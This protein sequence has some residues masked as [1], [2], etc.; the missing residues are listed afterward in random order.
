MLI[1][2]SGC[3]SLIPPRP[4]I[5][6]P[7]DTPAVAAQSS[8]EKVVVVEAPGER[9]QGNWEDWY[10]FQIGGQIVGRSHTRASTVIDSELIRT[11]DPEVRFEREES[12]IY[13]TGALQFTQRRET[14]SVESYDGSLKSFEIETQT[15]P[16]SILHQAT[17]TKETLRLGIVRGRERDSRQLTWDSTTRGLFAVEQSLRRRPMQSGETRRLRTAVPSLDAIGLTVLRCIGDASVPMIAGDFRVLTEIELELLD[18]ENR[19]V[20]E[21]L[22]WTDKDGVI[23]KSLRP[24]LRL[25]S[26]RVTS[27]KAKELFSNED[28]EVRVWLSGN[29]DLARRPTMVAML[30]RV[31]A[32]TE[33]E[34]DSSVIDALFQPAQRQSLRPGQ[35]G[36][37]VLYSIDEAP[38]GFEVFESSVRAT[39]TAAT[40]LLDYKQSDV[41]RLSKVVGE[42]PPA[43]LLTELRSIG[44]NVLSIAPQRGTR[45]ASMVVRSE[46]AGELDHTVVLAALLRSRAIPARVVLGLRPTKSEQDGAVAMRLSS[47]V[48]ASI[49]NRWV[50]VDP[51]RKS[52]ND[53]RVT[54]RV[55]EGDEDLLGS[56]EEVFRKIANVA[57]EIRGVR[58]EPDG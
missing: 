14:S 22:L 54:L 18:A 21:M 24:G 15:G 1:A 26:Y 17:V 35:T 55:C 56:I 46:R 7:A 31:G 10:V 39:D 3:D 23:Q 57:I 9:F 58:Y 12:L 6:V 51:L 50:I 16:V 53:F 20:G 40:E 41:A 28:E 8:E 44:N 52:E 42:L 47:W 29:L 33:T 30:V 11:G 25:E 38:E 5:G 2:V 13:R 36:L 19:V 37:Q 32:A 48:M 49:E 45:R 43:E 27:S 4:P 34:V